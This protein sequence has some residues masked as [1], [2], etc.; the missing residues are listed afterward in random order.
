MSAAQSYFAVVAQDD[1]SPD[2]L[3]S[4]SPDPFHLPSLL[5]LVGLNLRLSL[6][7]PPV[8]AAGAKARGAGAWLGT[9]VLFSAIFL[10]GV[11]CGSGRAGGLCKEVW[12]SGVVFRA[13]GG[14]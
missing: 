1:G 10:A 14:R 2:L 5:H 11:A 8:L 13:F 12:K 3:S 7:P 9:A 6:L 4:I